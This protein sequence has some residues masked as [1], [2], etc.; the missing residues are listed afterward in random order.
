LPAPDS[1]T[2]QGIFSQHTY[3]AGP[4]EKDAQVALSCRVARVPN[5]KL[6]ASDLKTHN[7]DDVW[8]GCF[9]KSCADGKPRDG[10]PIDMI[11]VLDISG[12]MNGGLGNSRDGRSRLQLAKE[13]LAGLLPK[14]RS[15]DRFGLATFTN[16]GTVIQSLEFIRELDNEVVWQSIQ[17]L[18]AGGGTTIQAGMDAAVGICENSSET[19]GARHRRLLFLTDMCDCGSSDLENMI[20]SQA[21][22]G[23]Y[24]S[25]VGIGMDFNAALAEQVTHHRGANY[26]CITRDEE[27]QKVIVDDFDWNFFPAAFEVEIAQ[28]SD[29]FELVGVYGTPFDTEKE[30]VVS[31]WGPDSHKF[32][33]SEFKDRAKELLLCSLRQTP[34]GL[35]APALQATLSYLDSD[36]RTIIRVDTVFPSA[37]TEDGSVEGGLILLRMRPRKPAI[38]SGTV[39]LMLRYLSNGTEVS[40]CQ[41]VSI[42]SPEVE[43]IAE[44]STQDPAI[45]KGVRLQSYVEVCKNFLLNA[46]SEKNCSEGDA[47]RM[48]AA[49]DSI[50]NLLDKFEHD[51]D[52]VD[53]SCPG[54]RAS[55]KDFAGMAS[56]HFD[57]MKPDAA[58]A[59][60]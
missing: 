2:Y 57:G 39:R 54:V 6:E 20:A 21:K 32:Y 4:P 13:A 17:S 10:V 16:T 9:L 23:L 26:F 59:A 34:H 40:K 36:V 25:F 43:P 12:S 27:L 11:V 33:S 44:L 58:S 31:D 14:L 52:D 37:V 50:N 47:V 18:Q 56:R 41:D 53:A 42:I 22:H 24:V 1:I 5:V 45:V 19:E 30:V 29:A 7:D 49:L 35:P 38:S 46:H 51:A 3:Y 8:I 60:N 55:L 15:E 28:Q 48:R